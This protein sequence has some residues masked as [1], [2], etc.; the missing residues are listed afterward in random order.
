MAAARLQATE[1]SADKKPDQQESDITSQKA[2]I[3]TPSPRPN[4]SVTNFES[5]V[6]HSNSI[7]TITESASRADLKGGHVSGSVR[8]PAMVIL[9]K[10]QVE[11]LPNRYQAV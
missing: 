9:P 7:H 4:G 1:A 10:R 8:S 3:H 6:Q 5:P 11:H 2:S